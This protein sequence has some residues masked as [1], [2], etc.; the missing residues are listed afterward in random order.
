MKVEPPTLEEVGLMGMRQT[1]ISA[2]QWT[3]QP[4]GLLAELI[5]KK[6]T[7]IAWDF[8]QNENGIFPLVRAMGEIAGN[9]SILI[10]G[11]LL[12]GPQGRGTLFGGVS[13][14]PPTEVVIIG[15]GTV[16]EFAAR[17]ALGLGASVKL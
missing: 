16:G 11:D 17:A 8:L 10:A 14:V 4:T 3:V 13:G 6:V 12:A 7:A 9:S 2:L 1:L 5:A 15:A